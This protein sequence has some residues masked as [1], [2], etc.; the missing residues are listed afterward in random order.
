MST[1]STIIPSF[2]ATWLKLI[3]PGECYEEFFI[4][5]N[6]LHVLCAKILIS[7]CL[8]YAI[9]CGSCIV[10]VPQLI[11]I[12]K[13]KSGEG[14]SLPSVT[15]ELVAISATWAY[16]KGHNFPFSSYGESIFLAIQTSIIAFLVL[17]FSNQLTKGLVYVAVYAGTLAFLLSPS[18][19]MS[20]LAV[21][22][23]ANIVLVSFSKMIQAVSNYNNGSTG[24]L[25][26]ITVYLLFLGSIARIFTSVQET[27]DMFVV[28]TY[29]VAT[30]FNGV[31]AAQM[32]YYWNTTPSP[33][34]Q[35]KKS[36]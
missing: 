32:I 20:L 3:A 34:E 24:Q 5:L 15:F 29:C 35:S 9:I 33:Q 17:A 23:G 26:V 22:Q 36:S 19:P 7:K 30:L 25:S 31:I 12:L 10:K 27:G 2:L 18:A 16:G 6:F 8:G 11:K 28:I 13:A 21:L 14:I 4:K 1:N